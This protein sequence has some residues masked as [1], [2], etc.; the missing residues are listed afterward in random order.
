VTIRYFDSLSPDSEH[1]IYAGA[2]DDSTW[3]LFIRDIDDEF[4]ITAHQLTS[5]EPSS[6]NVERALRGKMKRHGGHKWHDFGF[7]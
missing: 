2:Q 7:F 4:G 5:Y 6:G 3:V 1:L